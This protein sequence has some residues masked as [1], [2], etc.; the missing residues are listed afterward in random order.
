MDSPYELTNEEKILVHLATAI[1]KIIVESNS[2]ELE[3]FGKI[4]Y[5]GQIGSQVYLHMKDKAGY[6]WGEMIMGHFPFD[7]VFFYLIGLYVGWR[8]GSRKKK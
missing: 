5:T 1:R 8:I 3:V 4:E 2:P 7:H 6:V